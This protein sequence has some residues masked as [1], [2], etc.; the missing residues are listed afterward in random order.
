M[1]DLPRDH[2]VG[3]LATGECT[4]T[5]APFL[6]ALTG[7]DSGV[8]ADKTPRDLTS[9]ELRTFCEYTVDQ[10]GGENVSEQCTVSGQT[11]TVTSG[12][13]ASCISQA[14]SACPGVTVGEYQDCYEQV[15]S[16][17]DLYTVPACTQ[18]LQASQ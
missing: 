7:S 3:D 4:T 9:E 14:P 13:V 17:C 8:P 18:I 5:C 1:R 2:D 12:T 11:V 6:G 15:G 16:L 10:L